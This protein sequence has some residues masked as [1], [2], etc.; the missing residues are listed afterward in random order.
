MALQLVFISLLLL[1][2]ILL[3]RWVTEQ[4]LVKEALRLEAESFIAEYREDPNFPLPHTR[5]LIGYL[6]PSKDKH[7]LPPPLRHLPEGLTA[8]VF[9]SEDY[10]QVPV[11]VQ[12]FDDKR[13][14]LVYLEANVDKL[15]FLFGILPLTLIL[16]LLYLGTW[17]SYRLTWGAISP[18]LHLA[19]QVRGMEPE[20][21]QAIFDRELPKLKGEVAELGEALQHYSQRIDQLIKRERQFTSDASHELRTPVTILDGAI[22][23]LLTDPSLSEKAQ[24]RLTMMKKASRDL[25][26]L[27]HV[28]LL[29]ARESTI[30][31]DESPHPIVPLVSEEIEKLQPLTSENSLEIELIVIS[32][33]RVHAPHQV[34]RIILS[35][36]IRNAI[37]YSNG[38]KIEIKIF[39]DTIQICDNGPGIEPELLPH[40]FERHV[41][42]RGHNKAGEG[43]G[44]SI[45]KRLVDDFD[46]QIQYENR[47][48]GGLAV[49]LKEIHVHQ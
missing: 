30:V 14:H 41:R 1:I 17:I 42:G 9:Y 39:T 40:I 25:A 12:S 29:L 33:W 23:M 45:V 11:F 18:V 24:S 22:Q 7:L 49:T 4:I 44:L 31:N 21:A 34:V 5:N 35:N 46:F 8:E 13:L 6:N 37:N 2:T 36:L 20:N 32:D 48:Q 3:V 28:F 15:V 47:P 43:I 27:I 16:M 19:K 26:E 38:G 10:Q